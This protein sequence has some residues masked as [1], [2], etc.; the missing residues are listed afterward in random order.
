[1][2]VVAWTLT[3]ADGEPLTTGDLKIYEITL[4]E[5]VDGAGTCSCDAG[6]A[7][8]GAAVVSLCVDDALG[9]VDSDGSYDLQ[10]PPDTTPG[11]YL[12]RV[13]LAEDPGAVFGC[14]YGFS[15]EEPE[16]EEEEPGL[17]VVETAPGVSLE[18]ESGLSA[19][20]GEPFT[21]RWTYD[22]GSEDETGGAGG[23]AGDFAVELYS[24]EGLACVDG[25]CPRYMSICRIVGLWYNAQQLDRLKWRCNSS[26]GVSCFV[27]FVFRRPPPPLRS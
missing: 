20:P 6:G 24:C 4:E 18:V 8:D 3:P 11:F 23:S 27:S 22:D 17:D 2:F 9:C 21:A 1:M 19:F 5:C 7:P 16:E 26:T 14:T 15:V 13:S 10:V 12:V 25:R